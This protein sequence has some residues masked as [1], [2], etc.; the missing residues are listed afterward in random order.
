M[1][2]ISEAQKAKM[3]IERNVLLAMHKLCST[4]HTRFV[5]YQTL[6]IE[7]ITTDCIVVSTDGRRL[8]A[9]KAGEV[10]GDP[11]ERP[12]EFIVPINPA[13][14]K[15][16]P[17]DENEALGVVFDYRYDPNDGMV[18]SGTATF[19]GVSGSPYYTEQLVLGNYPKW[20]QLMPKL[21]ETLASPI[22]PYFN[23]ELLK[24]FY[25]VAA[26]M[27]GRRNVPG[28]RLRQQAKQ[29]PDDPSPPLMVFLPSVP[30]FIGILMPMVSAKEE[31]G[32]PYW[33]MLPEPKPAPA[34]EPAKPEEQPA[35]T[36]ANAA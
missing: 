28:V 34:V 11:P 25:A 13:M 27:R 31:L 35:A 14:L 20:R 12:V 4:D 18:I 22:D 19:A 3:T 17:L 5:I 30:E 9:M 26:T 33:A 16:L 21:D 29:K 10:Y 23:W 15:A 6:C 7:V 8:G 2:Q 36:P 24:G 32:V 1:K